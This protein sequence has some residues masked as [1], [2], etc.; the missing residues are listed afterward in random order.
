MALLKYPP[1]S[2][3]HKTLRSMLYIHKVIYHHNIIGHLDPFRRKDCFHQHPL[4]GPSARLSQ[5][6][7]SFCSFKFAPFG[8]FS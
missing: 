3:L 4:L 5:L 6:P 8:V 2:H 1:K 7:I